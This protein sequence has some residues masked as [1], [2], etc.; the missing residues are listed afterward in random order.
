[1][2]TELSFYW[3]K[4]RLIAFGKIMFVSILVIF[5]VRF[6]LTS[7]GEKGRTKQKLTGYEQNLP[8]ELKGLKVYEVDIDGIS[9]VKVAVLNGQVNSTT[10]SVGKYTE[11]T[12][13]LDPADQYGDVYGE[14]R[15]TITAKEVIYENDSI[16]IIKK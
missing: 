3:Y 14:N 11:T 8:Q 2:K 1:M 13:I 7:C 9:T 16:I 15:R 12:I 4:A 6:G 5:A 10:Y